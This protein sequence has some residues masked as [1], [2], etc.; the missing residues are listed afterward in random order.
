MTSPEPTVEYL[1]TMHAACFRERLEELLA[2]RITP[3]ELRIIRGGQA[4]ID[5]RVA[6]Y[7]ETLLKHL[8][9]CYADRDMRERERECLCRP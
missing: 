1:A 7:H 5:R 2:L 4:A 6:S 9:Q 3:E 8:K